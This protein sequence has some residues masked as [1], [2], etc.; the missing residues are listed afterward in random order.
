MNKYFSLVGYNLAFK[1]PNPSKQFAEYLPKLNSSGSFFFNPVS[2]EI[3]LEIMTLPQNKA[4][5][6]YSLPIRI[7]R[8]AKH[9]ISQPLSIIIN[10][11]LECGTYPSKLK[12]AEVIPI[13]KNDDES[14]PSNYRPISL[15]SVVNRI[16]ENMMYHRLKCFLEKRDILNDSQYGFREKRFT[17][18]AI[19]DII[20]QIENNMDKKMSSCGILIDLRKA[21][22]TVDHS[23]LLQKLN[24]YGI[25]G[26]V[27]KWFA[28]YLTAAEK[29]HVEVVKALHKAGGVADQT[30]LHH[31]AKNN[32]LDVV[33]YLLEIGVKDECMKCDGSFY[34]LNSLHRQVRFKRFRYVDSINRIREEESIPQNGITSYGELFDDK[35]L[36]Y[37]ETTLH[38]AISSGHNEVVKELISRDKGAL[39]CQ[40]CSGRTP[41]QEA[42][43]RNKKDIVNFLL[44][45]D[46]TEI[47][48]TCNRFQEMSS[49]FLQLLVSHSELKEYKKD[50]CHCG[51][52][53]L[54]LAARY[55]NWE[56]ASN[57]LE[58][59]A[60]VEAKDCFGATPMHVAA[61]H[62]QADMVDVLVKF[63]A[64]IN[65]KTYN[66]STPLHS[67]AVC[68]ASEVIDRLLYHG[69]ILEAADD[70]AF[71]ALH[72]CILYVNSTQLNDYVFDIE[73]RSITDRRGY[74]AKFYRQL[75]N[76]HIKNTNF[77]GWL[78]ALINLIL[79]GSN[80]NAVDS[81]GRTALHLAAAN[82][83]A[84]AVNVLL[85]RKAQIELPDESGQTPLVAAIKNAAVAPRERILHTGKSMFE[86]QKH[87]RD[88][89]MVVYLLL[90][91][92]AF[93]KDCNHSGES[94]LNI[95]IEKNQLLIVQLLLLKGASV[96]CED[97]QGRTPLLTYLHGGGY[98][99][100]GILKGFDISVDIK[101]GEPFNISEFHLL[102]YKPPTLKEDN[103]FQ[104]ISSDDY[105]L[106]RRKGPI[107]IAIENHP[108]K[109]RVIDSCLDAEGF[110][111]LHRAAQGANTLA[112]SI[113]THL[114]ANQS[115][116]SPHG[117]DAL[118][119]ALLHAGNTS[120][121]SFDEERVYRASLV[122][123]DLLHHRMVTSGYKIICDSSR[124][125]LTL[126]HLAASR[127]LVHFIQEIF[128]DKELHQLD[129]DC[130]NKDG[131]T[132]M[133]LAKMYGI[134]HISFNH[135]HFNPW[136]DVEQF[137]KNQ[138]ARMQYPNRDAE[139]KLIHGRL[140]GWIPKYRNLIA[141]TEVRD[142]FIEFLSSF[143]HGMP[144]PKGCGSIFLTQ[145]M[146][147][148][149]FRT[150]DSELQRQ[151]LVLKRQGF[152]SR[153]SRNPCSNEVRKYNV[154]LST[155]SRQKYIFHRK[156]ELENTILY[157]L[158]MW[159]LE[160]FGLLSCYKKAFYKYRQHF[161]D[162]SELN[163]L[164][165][166]YEN[167]IS[168]RYLYEMCSEV[169]SALAENLHFYLHNDDYEEFK[170]LYQYYPRFLEDRLGR[171]VDSW[172]WWSNF[173]PELSCPLSETMINS[174][175]DYLNILNVGLEPET[176]ISFN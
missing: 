24:H 93:L 170:I 87:L 78:D 26:I 42:V 145:M 155:Y 97:N 81:H 71:T 99:V 1:T 21:F 134:R 47:H 59:N 29:G 6:S 62:N 175:L 146:S 34:W 157:L 128:K 75:V 113:L 43:R 106:S 114:G 60:V 168:A 130:P 103:L 11:S 126:Y 174:Q 127:G 121:L 68:G 74:L 94:L 109:Y 33:K 58:N 52:S 70:S 137:I 169:S 86:L 112:V 142:F 148:V 18:H 160:V 23:I 173:E 3:E 115:S 49:F 89:E 91:S 144:F 10:K 101:C 57:L 19:L 79:H 107:L 4:H 162:A 63:G 22:D 172:L 8:S 117:Y 171:P 84:D 17:E 37:C 135:G 46:Q 163:L 12:L 124:A 118:T 20:S 38:A 90:S 67:A 129:V 9:V 149:Q 120:W 31:A 35:H 139:C 132:P 119:L 27:N 56:I 105:S 7:L 123:L 154:R 98:W 158:E 152:R 53:S 147:F 166:Q 54:H 125:E 73:T 153:I 110:T 136:A 66:G 102:F 80:L 30:A 40:D 159:H 16:F 116:L 2:P 88:H 133:Y 28:S 141:R 138:G 108:L 140:H 5:G 167:D 36:M 122:A 92:G 131:I 13:H 176:R 69:A 15:L 95:A 151:L 104:Q 96:K 48:A 61:C 41:L 83:L 65:S 164:I 44:K 82:G 32:K 25:R 161:V 45:E 143:R 72:Y 156:N 51:Y 165:Q 39:A 111:P 85:Q 64:G 14:D 77:Y 50:V 100:D 150:L 76:N 55:G